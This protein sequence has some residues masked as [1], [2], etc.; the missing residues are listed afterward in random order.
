MPPK[1]AYLEF[2]ANKD[3]EMEFY[4]AEQ[5]GM[6]VAALRRDMSGDEYVRWVIY[7]GRKAQRRQLGQG[8]PE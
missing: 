6:T 7:Y 1:V 8:L 3:L 2:E 5:L 4:V